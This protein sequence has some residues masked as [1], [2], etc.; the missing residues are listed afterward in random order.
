MYETI[1][2]LYNNFCDSN[3]QRV[4]LI[5]ALNSADNM[6]KTGD[7][8]DICYGTPINQTKYDELFKVTMTLCDICMSETDSAQ[9][10]QINGNYT[11]LKSWK[12][13]GKE[14]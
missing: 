6:S 7:S 4:P 10:A 3:V 9:R 1:W 14:I 8:A 11:Q 12:F 2:A 13:T 5:S